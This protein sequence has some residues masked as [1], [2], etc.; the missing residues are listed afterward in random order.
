MNIIEPPMYNLG[1]SIVIAEITKDGILFSADKRL[2]NSEDGTYE[3]TF[4]K[5]FSVGN[6]VVIGIVGKRVL[7]PQLYSKV[8]NRHASVLASK[9][10]RECATWIAESL[11]DFHD[12]EN[13][14]PEI[15][16]IVSGYDGGQPEIYETCITDMV[17]L[18]IDRNPYFVTK[19]HVSYEITEEGL[20]VVRKYSYNKTS[21]KKAL[22]NH[23]HIIR[24]DMKED[25]SISEVFDSYLI[26]S[27]SIISL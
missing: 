18:P 4:M 7:Y 5:A 3:D 20:N 16:L 14:P 2:T 21:Y 6:R 9:P 23:D 26:K 1:M 11:S 27:N 15:K 8:L 24:V 22:E 12:L 25:I 19:D 10:V 17:G 13:D